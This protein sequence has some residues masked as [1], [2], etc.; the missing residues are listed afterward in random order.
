MNSLL[1]QLKRAF[2]EVFLD[3]AVLIT[4]IGGLF[5]Y[6]ALYPQPYL[7]DLPEQQLVA[8][9][10][11]DRTTA[12]R[13][14]SRW[15]D[16]S[17]E[18]KIHHQVDS[19]AEARALLLKGEVRGM[20]TIPDNYMKSSLLGRSPVIGLAGDA[21]Y[22]LVY[23]TIAAGA[24]GAVQAV[25]AELRL[26]SLMNQGEPVTAAMQHWLPLRLNSRPLFN[27][28][29]GYLG[30]VIPAVFILIL[31]QTLL[32]ASGLVGAG[33]NERLNT[34]MLDGQ[35]WSPRQILAS[36]FVV[37]FLLYLVMAQF[38][39][40]ICF[41]FYGISRLASLTDLLLMISA[42]T[43]ATTSLGLLVGVILP[44]RELAAPLVMIS[45]L[46]LVFS[47]GF[48][49][50]LESIPEPIATLSTLAP[51]MSAI[52]GFLKLNQMGATF[53]DVLNH[54][55]WLW[56]LTFVFLVGAWLVM[57]HKIMARQY[58]LVIEVPNPDERR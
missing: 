27:V 19:I 58:S 44:R 40:G 10:D 56:V 8:L 30:Y 57:R 5:F 15:I 51:S 46:P 52:Q 32:L 48:V 43:A 41:E 25:G 36:R 21:N 42:F 11:L 37:M 13:K 9:V 20:I 54:W 17:P 28:S 34:G 2:N 23:G 50:P 55:R 1:H 47:A 45:S 6:A 26:L 31:H 22:F 18:V 3:R 38:F 49:W 24:A 33:F 29:M 35:Q 39:M 53:G 14:L 7:S 16:A 12:S 4:V